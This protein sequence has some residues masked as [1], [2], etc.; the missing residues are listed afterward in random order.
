MPALTAATVPDTM[1]AMKKLRMLLIAACLPLAACSG[2]RDGVVVAK[3]ARAEMPAVYEET[4]TQF[5]FRYEPAVYWVAI[6]GK[7]RHGRERIRNVLL[8]R[9]DWETLRV[10]DHW[11][12]KGGC[13]PAEAGGK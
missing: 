5:D 11:S 7:D 8:F 4:C 12:A 13:S 6:Q 9:H 3:H 2:I 10:G 1:R